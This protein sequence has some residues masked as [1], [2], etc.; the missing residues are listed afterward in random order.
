MSFHC[1]AD[2]IQI[3][4]PLKKGDINDL[5]ILAAC[6]KDLTNWMSTNVLHLNDLGLLLKNSYLFISLFISMLLT[7]LSDLISVHQPSRTRRSEDQ[8]QLKT[9]RLKHRGDRAFEV[10]GPNIY[11]YMCDFFV[12]SSF[13]CVLGLYWFLCIGIWIVKHLGQWTF[14]LWCYINKKTNTK[15]HKHFCHTYSTTGKTLA[16]HI[17]Q[18]LTHCFQIW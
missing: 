10:A 18:M 9:W 1:F 4:L 12:L 13:N 14:E 3:Y 7:Y 8:I 17:L 5:N 15:I 6:F 16:K 11:N 2:D